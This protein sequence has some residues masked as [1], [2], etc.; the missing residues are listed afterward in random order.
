MAFIYYRNVV[1]AIVYGQVGTDHLGDYHCCTALGI[2]GWGG[3]GGTTD[4]VEEGEGEEGG[5]PF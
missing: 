3:G 1:L 2:D 4:G 5:F